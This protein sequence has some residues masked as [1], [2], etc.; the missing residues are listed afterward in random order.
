MKN[1]LKNLRRFSVLILSILVLSLQ[2]IIPV[3]A[4]GLE[5]LISNGIPYYIPGDT[6]AAGT[7]GTVDASLPKD[8]IDAVNKNKSIYE[9]AARKTNLP[10][11][12]LAGIHYRESNMNTSKDLQAGNPIGGPYKQASTSYARYGYPST[13]EESVIIAGK[14]LQSKAVA[15]IFGKNINAAA[16]DSE[17][18]KD[19]L[20]GYNGRA[21]VYVDQA[22]SLGFDPVKQPYEG[23]PY[24]MSRYDA[25]HTDMKIITK[26]FGG[27]DGIDKRFGAFTIYVLLGGP[28]SGAAAGLCTG[29]AVLGDAVKTAINYSWPKYRDP[30]VNATYARALKPAYA[31]ALNTAHPPGCYPTGTPGCEYI[32]GGAYPGVDCGGFVTRVMRDSKADPEYNKYQGRVTEQHRYLEDQVKAGKYIKIT[33]VKTTDTLHGG[34]IWINSGMTHTY[35]YVGANDGFSRN[36]ASASFEERAPMASNAYDIGETWYR[37]K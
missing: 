37:L 31:Q 14:E 26:D 12:V 8:F 1:N 29:S 22:A 32:G 25:A 9:S 3:Y 11:E 23:S 28:T 19:A 13:F 4:E 7:L 18:I 30:D 27:L 6:C 17:L 36:S 20:F 10:W 21:G 24:V 33:G 5:E 34:D 15:G 16:I 2:P 35:M